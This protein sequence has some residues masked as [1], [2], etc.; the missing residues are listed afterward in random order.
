MFSFL[1]WLIIGLIAGALARF[2]MP[3]RTQ[4]L[5]GDNTSWIVGSVIEAW[6][7]ASFGAAIRFPSGRPIPFT[8]RGDLRPLDM[9]ND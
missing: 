9:A 7:A 6:S 2:I 5:T 3:A 4:W 1:W 8:P